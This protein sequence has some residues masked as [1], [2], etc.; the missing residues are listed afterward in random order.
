VRD[1]ELQIPEDRAGK[2][3]LFKLMKARRI[4]RAREDPSDFI[5]YCFTH[6]KTG[7]PLRN[8]QFHR[9]WQEFFSTCRYGVIEAAV[10]FGK[11][12]Q[13]GV[14]RIIWEIG[15]DPNV[16]IVLLG[17][18]EDAAEKLARRIRREIDYNPR[19]KEVFPNLR[20][21]GRRGDSWSDSDFTVARTL[22]MTDPTVQAR[23]V[24]SRNLNGSRSDI[25]VIDDLL[26]FD[27]TH[28]I[29]VRNK[30][31]VWFD[32]IVLS[33]VQDDYE[34]GEYGRCFWIGNPWHADDL[35][36]RL[37]KRPGWRHMTTAVVE[38]PE[39]PESQWR[40]KWP[41]QWPLQ[42]IFDKRSTMAM[43]SFS[44]ARKYLCLILDE[45]QRRF[46]RSWINHMLAQG[47][48]RE[49]LEK[50]PVGRYGAPLRCFTGLDPGVGEKDIDAV[51]CL[52]TVAI[53][54]A[55]RRCVIDIRSGRWTGPELLDQ[56]ESVSKTYDS[57]LVVESNATQRWMQQFAQ[58][59]G[60]N[61]RTFF[62]GA[63]NKWSEEYGVESLAIEM[64]N[65]LWIAPSGRDGESIPEEV[66]SWC[67]ECLDYDPGMHTGDRLMAS[68]L[69]REGARQWTQPRSQRSNHMAR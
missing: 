14:G 11:S 4:A 37:K 47:R 68:W 33:R 41:R 6:D 35:S 48:G 8:E 61:A 57:E 50:Q 12:I 18:N 9:D 65:G 58:D 32:E 2:L 43:S 69:A 3:K 25:I 54:H 66:S 15:T 67:S 17:A 16:R 38:N 24:G 53:D 52:F 34:T 64:K 10:E 5:E 30:L 23:S 27:V 21:S 63:H 44:F 1:V 28:S 59:R 62:T 45:A 20:R 49:L 7:A 26:N 42:R 19:I 22:E 29:L 60:I 31:E 36:Q 56:C 39:A 51:S 55:G 13:I 46:K 40:P